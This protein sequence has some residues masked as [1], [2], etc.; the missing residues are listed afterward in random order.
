MKVNI[1]YNENWMRYYLVV[2]TL[3]TLGFVKVQAIW[4]KPSQGLLKLVSFICASSP[5]KYSFQ[6]IAILF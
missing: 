2:T 4:A 1:V 5:I 6:I 3:S